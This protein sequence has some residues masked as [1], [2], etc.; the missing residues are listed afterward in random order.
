M[1]RYLVPLGL[2]LAIVVLLGMGLTLNPR[3]V[4]S[5][6]VGRPAPSFSLPTVK[7]PEQT[8]GRADLLGKVSLLNVWA[9]WCISCRREHGM[10]LD[11]AQQDLVPI[12]GL[13]YKDNRDDAV[14]W[15]GQ[16]GDPYVA[17]AFDEAGRVGS[18]LGVYGAPETYVV[19]PQGMIAYKHIGPIT[20]DSWREQILPVVQELLDLK[21]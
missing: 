3:L 19:D 11:I 2:F 5:P 15:L 16:L 6:L 8:L 21:P 4:P 20:P 9:T 12:Y 7:A 14:R 1:N 18:D 17:S 13:N 10:L